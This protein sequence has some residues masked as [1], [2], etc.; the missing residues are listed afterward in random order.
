MAV[1]AAEASPTHPPLAVAPLQEGPAQAVATMESRIAAVL[2]IN[3]TVCQYNVAQV[4]ANL[5]QQHKQNNHN[6]IPTLIRGVDPSKDLTWI[7]VGIDLA[8]KGYSVD[9][10][11]EFTFDPQHVD[12]AA[13]LTSALAT[14]PRAD[15]APKMN[16]I[17]LC[18]NAI[19]DSLGNS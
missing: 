8:T 18:F 5:V 14:L 3:L 6:Y 11:L 4:L 16:A 7:A 17:L 15:M 10:R 2:P 12:L 19:A 1:P 9:D 13:K